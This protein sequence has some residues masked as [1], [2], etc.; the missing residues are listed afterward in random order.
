MHRE[1]MVDKQDKKLGWMRKII[2]ISRSEV[3]TG[4]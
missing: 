3:Q 4:K 1:R 2:A